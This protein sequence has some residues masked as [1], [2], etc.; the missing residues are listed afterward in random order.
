MSYVSLMVTTKQKQKPRV[1]ALKIEKGEAEHTAIENYA[2]TKVV[3]GNN[4]KTKY[5]KTVR[6]H[7]KILHSNNFKCRW[8][9]LTNQKTEWLDE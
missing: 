6:W 4:G 5:Q 8:I 7:Y 9:E 1:D 3:K 2:F